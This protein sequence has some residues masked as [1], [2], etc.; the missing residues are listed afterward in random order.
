M[1]AIIDGFNWIISFFKTIFDFIMTTFET[2]AM[3]FRYIATIV[4]LAFTVILT[5]PTWLQAFG[6]IT[7]SVCSVYIVIGREAGKSKE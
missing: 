5:L 1:Q 7:I 2:L 3:V 6:I 4:Q